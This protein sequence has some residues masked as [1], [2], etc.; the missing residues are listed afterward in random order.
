[1]DPHHWQSLREL[2][3]DPDLGLPATD[4]QEAA[5][6]YE[7]GLSLIR[8]GDSEQAWRAFRRAD[9]VGHPGAPRE[10]GGGHWAEGDLVAAAGCYERAFQRG[11]GRAAACLGELQKNQGDVVKALSYLRFADEAGDPEG[12]RGLGM[13]LEQLGNLDEAELALWRAD[14]RGSASGSLA[15]GLFLQGKRDNPAAAETAF[16][17]AQ[18]RGQPKGSAN[19]IEIYAERGEIDSMEVARERALELIERHKTVL[20]QMRTPQAL[21]TIRELGRTK[22]VA[23]TGGGG[24]AMATAGVLAALGAALALAAAM[25]RNV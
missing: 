13:L 18:E 21:E 11:D 23:A 7:R 17:H 9:E 19:L 12:S 22:A 3:G 4:D 2:F 14:S 5:A 6:E 8:A 25:G 20:D 24:C 15:L 10:I 16:L 1:M